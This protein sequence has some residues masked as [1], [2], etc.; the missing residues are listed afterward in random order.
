MD[1]YSKLMFAATMRRAASRDAWMTLHEDHYP[2]VARDV[3]VDPFTEV[4]ACSCG[5]RAEFTVVVGV[6][7]RSVAK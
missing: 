1:A 4:M 5:A 2:G 3:P 6:A 7:V